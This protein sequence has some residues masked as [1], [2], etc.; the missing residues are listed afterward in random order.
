VPPKI[1]D[2]DPNE[3]PLVEDPPAPPNPVL[4]RARRRLH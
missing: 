2:P 4:Q 1:H 3:S